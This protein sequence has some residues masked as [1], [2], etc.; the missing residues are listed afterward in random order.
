M[1]GP[2]RAGAARFPINTFDLAGAVGTDIRISEPERQVLE[3]VRAF[4]ERRL[5]AVVQA[6]EHDNI[7]PEEEVLA[8]KKLGLFGLLVPAEYGG[9]ELG[10]KVLALVFEELSR[11]WMGFAGILGSHT[12]MSSIIARF[13]TADQRRNYL[14][15][16]A[17]GELRGGTAITEP[18]AGSDVQAIRTFARRDGDGY[19]LNGTKAFLT[20]GVRG[21]VFIVVAKTDRQKNPASGGISLFIVERSHG[22]RVSSEMDKLGYKSV[23]TA[24]VV[25]DDVRLPASALLGESEGEGFRQIMAG[26]ESGR[27]NVAARAVGVARA[28]LEASLRYAQERHAFG[29]PIGKHQAV[30]LM[31]ADMATQIEAA[32]L[33]TLQSAAIK[34]RG[35]RADLAVGMAKLFASEVCAKVCLDALRI[36]GGYGYTKDFPVERYYR[37][38]PLMIIGEGTNEI[39]RQIIARE[40]LRRHRLD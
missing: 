11:V 21:D 33:L 12:M 7:Y 34:D 18:D 17:T 32:R 27:I 10:H 14:P 3:A 16:L 24:E 13:G 26:L 28:A 6:Y 1:E 23:D 35:G 36:H 19:I 22:I 29:K 5:G 38:A 30:Q 40:M 8:A 25:F 2:R 31:L 4:A 20:N 9:M 39:Q 15:R 37:D